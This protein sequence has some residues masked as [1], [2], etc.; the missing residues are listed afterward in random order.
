MNT[1]NGMRSMEMR[2]WKVPI[3]PVRL[4]ISPKRR[5]MALRVRTALRASR[6]G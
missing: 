6:V 3:G 5:S 1:A 2:S 4:R